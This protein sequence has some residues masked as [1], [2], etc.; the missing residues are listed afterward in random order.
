MSCDTIYK[1]V[2]HATCEG[3]RSPLRGAILTEKGTTLTLAD[4]KT[5]AGWKAILCPIFSASVFE[6]GVMI[7]FD[8]GIDVTTPDAE[9]TK[10]NVG[11]SEK[12]GDEE[13]AFTAFGAM[14]FDEYR[15]YFAADG[16]KFDIALVCKNG[17][18]LMTKKA[19]GTVKGFRGRIMVVKG[20]IPKQSG[21]LQKECKFMFFFDDAKEWENIIEIAP[22]DH[23]FT[24]IMDVVPVGLNVDVTTPYEGTG[25]TATVKITQRGSIEP[26]TALTNVVTQWQIVAAYNDATV[27]V[28]SVGVT[29]AATGTYAPVLTAGLVGPVYAR[30]S[31][32][33]ATQRTYVSNVFRIV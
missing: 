24:D 4:A 28:A 7:D 21:D 6:K 23:S 32:E 17:T 33:S 22:S 31:V 9:I 3:L 25:G 5:L 20:S 19:D 29:G 8:R 2:G 11:R 18:K 26:F 10:S 16:R 30:I 27:A 14:N 13:P 15:S 1:P 12:T